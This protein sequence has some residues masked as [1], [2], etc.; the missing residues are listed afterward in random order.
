MMMSLAGI[1]GGVLGNGVLDKGIGSRLLDGAG[2]LHR[3][4]VSAG[5]TAFDS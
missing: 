1:T 3:W 5:T 4:E 2:A